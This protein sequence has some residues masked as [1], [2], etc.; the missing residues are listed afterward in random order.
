MNLT[1]QIPGLKE[2]IA[3]E[4]FDRSAPFLGLPER[5]CGVDCRPLTLLDVLRLDCIGSPFLSGGEVD[6]MDVAAFLKLQAAQSNPLLRKWEIAR[7]S[8]RISFEAAVNQITEFLSESF[9]DAPPNSNAVDGPRYWTF[10]HDYIHLFASAYG[11]TTDHILS[12]P[13]KVLLP[14]LNVLRYMNDHKAPLFNPRSDK[15]RGQWLVARNTRN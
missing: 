11:W 8:R 10:A 3:Q 12:Q 9:A 15:V 2:A 13:V 1:D 6:G 4:R 14:Q 5:V 7:Q